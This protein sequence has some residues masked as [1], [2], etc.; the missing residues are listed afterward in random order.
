MQ[1][2][3]SR[4]VFSPSDLN[5]FLACEHLTALEL[6]V[7]R[8]ELARP[9]RDNPQGELIRRK[10]EEHEAAFLQAL[11]DA[12]KTVA[13]IAID[14]DEWDFERAAAD[15]LAA[16]RAGVDVVYQAAVLPGWRRPA[17]PGAP[18]MLRCPRFV[19][20]YLTK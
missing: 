13:A 11:R 3:D 9:E 14:E 4:L 6:A 7:A 5:A 19:A 8:G 1:Q 15:T 2:R 20:D 12:G 17:I 16:M 18:T 10:G